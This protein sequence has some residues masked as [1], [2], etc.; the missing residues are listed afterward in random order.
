[1]NINNLVFFDKNGESYNFNHNALGHWEGADYFLPVSTAL[2][3]CS[4]LFILEN[5]GPD[6]YK[7]PEMEVDSKFEIVWTTQNAKTNFFLFTVQLENPHSDS[8]RYLQNHD[9]ITISYSDFGQISGNLDLTYPMQVNVAFTP[10]AEIAYTRVLQIYYTTSTTRSLVLEMVFYGEGED[11]DER[12]RIWLTN[13][14]VKFNKEDA[15]LLKDYDLKEGLPDWQ[16]INLARKQLLVTIDQVYPYVGTYKGLVNLID[17]LGYRDVLRVKEYWQDSDTASAYYQKYAMVDVTDLMQIGDSTEINLV[18]ENGQIKRGGKFKKTEFLALSYQFTIA[19]DTYDEDGLPEVIETTDFPVN[20]IFFKLDGVARKL[21]EEILPI[22]VLIKDII[23][24]FIYFTKFNL[25]DWP[26]T[27]FIENSDLSDTYTITVL[28]PEIGSTDLKIRDLKSL[29]PKLTVDSIFPSITFNTGTAQPYQDAQHYPADQIPYLITAISDYYNSIKYN[30]FYHIG[31]ANALD[32]PDD[33]VDKIGCP[34]ILEAYISDLTLQQLDGITFGDFILSEATTSSSA[35]VIGIGSKMFGC[36]TVQPFRL[37]SKVKITMTTDQSSYMVGTVTAINEITNQIVVNVTEAFGTSYSNGWSINLID[38]HFTIGTLKYKNGY[39]IEWVITGPNDYYFQ[40]RDIVTTT[41]KIP[42]ILPYTGDYLILVKVHDMHGATSVDYKTITVKSEVPIL[43]AFIKIQDK[44]KYDIKTLHNI[45]IGDLADSPLYNPYATVINLNGENYP[46]SEIYTHYLDWFT[47]SQHYGIG[48]PQ[49]AVQIYDSLN[50][51]QNISLSANPVKNQWGTGSANGQPTIGDYASAKLSDM[52]FVNFGELGYVGDILDGFYLDLRN[53]KTDSPGSYTTSLQFGGFTPIGFFMLIQT[54]AELLIYLQSTTSPGW[55]DYTYQLFGDRIKATAKFQDKKSH[56]IIKQVSVLSGV[57]NATEYLPSS[58]DLDISSSMIKLG[59][60]TL[61]QTEMIG[62]SGPFWI[63]PSGPIGWLG[64]SGPYFEGVSGPSWIGTSGEFWIGPSGFFYSNPSDWPSSWPDYPNPLWPDP[65][66][67]DDPIWPS[68][69]GLTFPT[70]NSNTTLQPGDRLRI[71]NEFG[72]YAEGYVISLS[73]YQI[74]VE[75]DLI[76]DVDNF[77]YFNLSIIDT[78]Y[79]FN[80]PVHVFD[81]QSIAKVQLTLA[82]AD[83]ILDEDLLFLTCQFKDKLASTRLHT[84]PN[85]SDIRYWI[86]KGCIVYD[87]TLGIQTGYLPSDYDQNTLSMTSVRA[88]YNT[89][90]APLYHPVFIIISNLTS[91]VETEWTL[92]LNSNSIVTVKTTSY[93]VW[94]FVTPGEY[95]LHVKSTDTRGNVSVLDTT[96]TI[97][98]IMT[99][100]EY[101]KYV[102]KQLNNRKYQMTHQSNGPNK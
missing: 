35:Y 26:D 23:G 62:P 10:S 21:K 101:Q 51:F 96:V 25:R 14:G 32:N 6:I 86:N 69:S 65:Y 24:E 44:T 52:R 85:A 50:G 68:T 66:R 33:V 71:Q 36:A 34:I 77:E 37:G 102:E 48:N 49:E 59:L 19:G 31:E 8:T 42:H 45:T 7:F 22:N 30:E 5:I 53:L 90:I 92:T 54:A 40:W 61:I 39:E 91:N 46:L 98:V 13:F 63:G 56:S 15:L 83:L 20:E 2:F 76:N 4:N 89:I 79:T 11:E 87:N 29:Y 95:T 43:E 41:A 84:G 88:T 78:I 80:K 67:I 28:M 18:D 58:I 27:T 75:I 16:Q 94:R 38:T 55:T 82:D 73:D 3:D 72:G 57:F 99:V 70:V 9:S 17:I 93:F 1:M 97:S 81:Y 47:Y 74:E 64:P 60:C 12:Y 100:D